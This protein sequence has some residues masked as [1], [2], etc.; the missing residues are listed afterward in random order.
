M[1]SGNMRVLI[2]LAALM[3]PCLYSQ[4]IASGRDLNQ[5]ARPAT[6]RHSPEKTSSAHY[7]TFSTNLGSAPLTEMPA[8]SKTVRL[9]RQMHF[10]P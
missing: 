9:A 4:E 5:P 1:M 6:K 7:W 10:E 8:G 2:L 3:P